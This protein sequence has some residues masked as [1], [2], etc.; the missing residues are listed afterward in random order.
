MGLGSAVR[1]SFAAATR[2]PLLERTAG[3]PQRVSKAAGIP[4]PS[5]YL[6][7]AWISSRALKKTTCCSKFNAETYRVVRIQLSFTEPN[8]KEVCKN[9]KQCH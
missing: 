1:L 8:I 3:R 2:R 5:P 9:T 7:E 6:S 4:L